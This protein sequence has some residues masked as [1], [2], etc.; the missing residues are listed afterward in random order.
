MG[1]VVVV[2]IACFIVFSFYRAE[3]Q[4]NVDQLLS[5]NGDVLLF[6]DELVR[7]YLGG[8]VEDLL[9]V[10]H[11]RSLRDY[12]EDPADAKRLRFLQDLRNLSLHKKEYAQLRYLDVNGQEQVR[13]DSGGQAV[14]VDKLQN[15]L[16]RYYFTEGMRVASGTIYISP[17]DLNMENGQ[18]QL[19][20]VPMI[21][22]VLPIDDPERGRLGVMVLNFNARQLLERLR[23]MGNDAEAN[24]EL[25]NEAGY[26]LVHPDSA[27]EWGFM[28]PEGA[29]LSM[30]KLHPACWQQMF[31]TVVGYGEGGG[32]CSVLEAHTY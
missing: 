12:I 26:W 4:K 9:V 32:E 6:A 17:V 29:N 15:K 10:S 27:M 3:R 20:R 28:F 25:V 8:V 1:V 30:Q 22:F 23:L 24:V 31:G 16:S 7:T 2:L 14:P 18:V 19:P 21:R 11:S 13:V 5:E